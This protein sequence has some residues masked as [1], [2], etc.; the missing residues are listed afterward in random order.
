MQDLFLYLLLFLIELRNYHKK[1]VTDFLKT[2][3]FE[4]TIANQSGKS[5]KT[6]YYI[7]KR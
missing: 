5:S 4:Y 3:L 2:F 6:I 7:L 1:P